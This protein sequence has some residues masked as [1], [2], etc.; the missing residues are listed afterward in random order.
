MI[1]L[2]FEQNGFWSQQI[3]C[4]CVGLLFSHLIHSYDKQ[5]I[6]FLDCIIHPSS[7]YSTLPCAR[8]HYVQDT[9]EFHSEQTWFLY[10]SI[11]QPSLFLS[12]ALSVEK[13]YNDAG[14]SDTIVTL[15]LEWFLWL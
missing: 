15:L 10:R 4:M 2:L 13:T 11:C 3:F 5:K 7:I 14:F 8:N 6:Y 12:S 1:I 9:V